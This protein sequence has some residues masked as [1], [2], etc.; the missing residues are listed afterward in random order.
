MPD[1]SII[2]PVYNAHRY[3]EECIESIIAQSD[4]LKSEV[5]L[6]NDGSSD[7]SPEIC[8]SY[9]SEYSN[10]VTIHKETRASARRGTTV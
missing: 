2:I 7:G 10:I 5:I 4:F 9:S 1:V 8:D 3:L 6:I